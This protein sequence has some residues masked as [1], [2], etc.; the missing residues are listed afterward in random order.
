MGVQCKHSFLRVCRKVSGTLKDGRYLAEVEDLWLEMA[1]SHSM[2]W[3]EPVFE[4]I[5]SPFYFFSFLLTLSPPPPRDVKLR[6]RSG[7]R[8]P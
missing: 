8:A 4:G 6:L 5:F 3:F 7:I 2:S 1:G